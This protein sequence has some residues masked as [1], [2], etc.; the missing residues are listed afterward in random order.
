MNKLEEYE[1]KINYDV[2]GLDLTPSKKCAKLPP[3]KLLVE[4]S[5]YDKMVYLKNNWKALTKDCKTIQVSWPSFGVNSLLISNNV[6][7]S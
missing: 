3:K 7:E 1:S 6:C 2:M 4:P 5:Y